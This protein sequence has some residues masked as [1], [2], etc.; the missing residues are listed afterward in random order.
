MVLFVREG[1]SV[2]AWQAQHQAAD[3]DKSYLALVRGHLTG[4][5]QVDHPIRDK[6][7]GS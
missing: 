5:V 7:A 6:R 1:A 2:G 4:A 3:C